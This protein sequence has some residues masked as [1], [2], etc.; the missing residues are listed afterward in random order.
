MLDISLIEQ[1]TSVSRLVEKKQNVDR[2]IEM[3]N[4]RS[5]TLQPLQFFSHVGGMLLGNVLSEQLIACHMNIL[6]LQL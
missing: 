5:N 4:T 6:V 1:C 2:W 3:Q